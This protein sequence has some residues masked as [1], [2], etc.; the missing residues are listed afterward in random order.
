MTAITITGVA[1]WSH[2]SKPSKEQNIEVKGHKKTIPSKYSIDVFLSA[3]DANKL[4]KKGFNV[5][6]AKKEVPGIENAIGKPYLQVKKPAV[7]KSGD[8]T[9][10]PVCV[11]T[12]L[13]PYTGLIGNGSQVNV[14]VD[15]FE[16]EIMGREGIAA[17]LLGVQVVD[18]VEHK[19]SGAATGGFDVVEGFKAE[20]VSTP[21]EKESSSPDTLDTLAATVDDLE[22]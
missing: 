18:L 13:N 10:P 5:K 21:T 8:A 6:K 2:I 19:S 16:Y 3:D 12:S 15:P 7:Y 9:K 1:A 17:R 4:N 20:S 11:D 14:K 22:F